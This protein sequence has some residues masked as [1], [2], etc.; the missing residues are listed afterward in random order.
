MKYFVHYKKFVVVS[1]TGYSC[2]LNCKFCRGKY[3]RNMLPFSQDTAFDRFRILFEKG[4][5]GILLSGGFT[6]EGFLPIRGYLEQLKNAK[7]EYGFVYNAHLGLLQDKDLLSSLSEVIDVVDFEFTTSSFIINYIRNL[8]FSYNVYIK[9]LELMLDAGLHVVPHVYLW[10]PRSNA[11]VLRREFS[12]LQDHGIEEVTLLVYIPMNKNITK[13][14]RTEKL[15]EMLRMIKGKYDAKLYLGCMRP[16]EIKP[17]FDKYV[18]SEGLVE[19]IAN[20]SFD[21]V[22]EREAYYGVEIY[23]ACC[24]IPEGLLNT[25]KFEM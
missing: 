19:R 12:I 21:I 8:K 25:F 14:I 2:W 4:V 1:L 23:D 22:R 6:T 7:K 17:D 16:K 3:L 20:P 18:V 15:L 9:S 24:S 13:S 5:R 10:H 11:E